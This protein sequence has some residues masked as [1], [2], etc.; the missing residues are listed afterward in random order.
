MI[1]HSLPVFFTLRGTTMAQAKKKAEVKKPTEEK[2]ENYQGKE[3][4]SSKEY[5]V[6]EKNGL[7]TI[8]GRKSS[9]K[10][11]LRSEQARATYTFEK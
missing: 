8:K 5:D 11:V 10:A 7:I 3:V 4:I 2:V 1:D 9:F 6:V